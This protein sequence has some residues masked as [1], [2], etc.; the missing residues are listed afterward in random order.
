MRLQIKLLG[1]FE[2]ASDGPIRLPTRKTEALLAVLA[3]RP[4]VRH[5]RDQL[6]ALLWPHNDASQGRVNLRQTLSLLRRA[7]NGL[8]LPGVRTQADQVYLDPAGIEVDT[9][10]L[11]AA[12]A[13]GSRAALERIAALY[14]GDFLDTLVLPSEPFEE[15]RAQEQGRLRE[16]AIAALR[17]LL[18]LCVA[19]NQFEQAITLGERLLKLDPYAE[20]TYRALM[21]AYLAQ[22]ARGSAIR[23]Y[24]RCRR[25]LRTHLGADPSADMEALRRRIQDGALAQV[26]LPSRA[27]PGIAVLPFANLSGDPAQDYFSR[28]VVED[29]IA[30]LSRFRTLRVIARNSSFAAIQPGR[31]LPEIGAELGVEYLLEGSIRRAGQRLRITAQLSDAATGLHIWSE[32]YEAP[33]EQVFE[34][35]DRMIQAVVG[36]L[37]I[38]IDEELLRK[39]RRLGDGGLG[40]Y[41]CWLHGKECLD[42]GTPE[43]GA[44]VRD[45]FRQALDLNP[46][47][48]R[49]YAGMAMVYFSDWNCHGWD[50]WEQCETK[51]FDYARK[52]IALD[53]RDHVSHCILSRIHL[54]R[55][56]FEQASKHLERAMALNPNDADCLVRMAASQAQLGDSAAGVALGD[57]ALALNPRYPDWYVVF[58]GLANLMAARHERAVTLMER[59]PDAFI[60]V[61]AFLALSHAYLGQLDKA[62]EHAE[63]FRAAYERKIDPGRPADMTAAMRWVLHVT[64]FRLDSDAT[65]LRKGLKKAGIG[66]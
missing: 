33:V 54:F 58:V 52:A 45:F 36:A 14:R 25:S 57:A 23:Q 66:W 16:T 50:R 63:A 18:D 21:T 35:Q 44:Q 29:I 60:D 8:A 59:A 28:G 24:E 39:S 42:R 56:Q 1:P 51:A 6:G 65:Y 31:T 10:A 3:V 9:L 34:L 53:D 4:G 15:W 17:R 32:R 19:A 55:R 64:P 61:R 11:E 2:A 62:R 5:R 27:Q 30:E 22:G 49:G 38:R 7:L 20:E 13:D 47:Y 37:A 43:S 40:A 46:D 48:A 12:F 26:L 41:E